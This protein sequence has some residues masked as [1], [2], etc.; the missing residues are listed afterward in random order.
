MVSLTVGN[1]GGETAAERLQYLLN[2]KE[3]ERRK[4]KAEEQDG[5]GAIKVGKYTET[6]M[7]KEQ[8]EHTLEQLMFNTLDR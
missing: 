5:E 1:V 6:I 3:E 4:R 7:V 8:L 2:I